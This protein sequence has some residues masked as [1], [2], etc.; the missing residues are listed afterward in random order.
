MLAIRNGTHQRFAWLTSSATLSWLVHARRNWVG[1]NTITFDLFTL[2]AAVNSCH[3]VLCDWVKR[4]KKKIIFH[5]PL[6]VR[7]CFELVFH[8]ALIAADLTSHCSASVSCNEQLGG[9]ERRGRAT[10][11]SSISPE[12]NEMS[13]LFSNGRDEQ[14]AEGAIYSRI[15]AKEDSLF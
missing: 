2:C 15:S 3:H 12:G 1:A 14:T 8:F 10:F 7:A 11:K 9:S 5:F 6:F 4:K 13:T